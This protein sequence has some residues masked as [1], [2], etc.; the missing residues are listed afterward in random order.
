MARS[1]KGKGHGVHVGATP[2]SS[3]S[4]QGHVPGEG[5]REHLCFE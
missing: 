3:V 5:N 2:F 4:G 1:C